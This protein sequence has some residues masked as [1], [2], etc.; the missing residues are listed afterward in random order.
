MSRIEENLL[1]RIQNSSI[2]R[3]RAMLNSRLAIYYFHKGESERAISVVDKVRAWLRLNDRLDVMVYINLAE[4]TDK[5]QS[6]DTQEAIQKAK[7]AYALSAASGRRDLM[8]LSAAWLAHLDFN[9]GHYVD[10]VSMISVCLSSLDQAEPLAKTRCYTLL[11]D[12]LSFC[13]NSSEATPWYAKARAAAVEEG[14]EIAIGQ[15]I[16]NSA[17][18]RFNNLRLSQVRG[19]AVDDELRLLELM[20]SSSSHYDAGVNSKAFKSFLPMLNAQVLMFR[21][22]YKNASRIFAL[23]LKSSDALVDKRVKAICQADFALS[24][25]RNGDVGHAMNMVEASELQS[26]ILSPPDEAAIIY[27]QNAEIYSI[28]GALGKSQHCANRAL[29]ELN[30][31]QKVQKEITLLLS[32]ELGLAR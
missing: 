22:D 6:A 32:S 8:A 17:A 13:G 3:E 25:A 1:S 31:H 20:I 21:G 12:I 5:F 14:D 27:H 29:E 26:D 18:F 11:A 4:A 9:D 24:I 2:E 16:Y 28:A 7:R 23:W 19:E 15:I 30:K 10:A